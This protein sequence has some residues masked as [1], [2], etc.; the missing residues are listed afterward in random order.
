M[1]TISKIT[2]S[3]GGTR[4]EVRIKQD[5][6]LVN[7][8]RFSTLKAAK[9][10]SLRVEGDKDLLAA[11]GAGAG[12]VSF[13]DLADQ[14]LAQFTGKAHG[15]T[16]DVA[17]WKSQIGNARILSITVQRLNQILDKY[18][19]SP[20]Q[21]F[22]GKVKGVPQYKAQDRTPTAASVNSK[23]AAIIAI[24]KHGVSQG[25]LTDNV[26]NKMR[27]RSGEVKRQRYLTPDEESRLLAAARQ[28]HWPQMYLLVLAAIDTGARK[29]ELIGLKWA[30]V[31]LKGRTALLRDT[32]T[33]DDRRIPLSLAVVEEMLRHRQAANPYVFPGSIPGKP[34]DP[35][36][37]WERLLADTGIEGFRFHDLRHSAAS[38]LLS[39]GHSL[40][41]IGRLLGHKSAQ[42][43]IRYAHLLETKGREMVDTHAARRA[44]N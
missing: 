19:A 4:Y 33:G 10:Y 21:V 14:Y 32:K 30:D 43:T 26:A 16:G 13:S 35:R 44:V 12:T 17:W 18:E 1:A 34:M 42:T 38:F 29:G 11:M 25:L 5:R 31:D 39:A 24:L 27:R 7:K 41:E 8:K 6:K 2:L 22:I 40:D 15:R 28:S 20:V 9:A 37:A 36:K 23:R 3:N